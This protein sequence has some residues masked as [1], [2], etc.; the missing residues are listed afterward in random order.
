M[1]F[2]E[3][4]LWTKSTVEANAHSF[5][6]SNTDYDI[7]NY[8]SVYEK[9]EWMDIHADL[10]L[11]FMG[12][13]DHPVYHIT[14]L[15]DGAVKVHGAA[16]YMADKVESRTQVIKNLPCELFKISLHSRLTW[17]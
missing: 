15:T 17:P 12:E 1:F 3:S 16:G 11:E 2:P 6:L 4:N 10:K 7:K 9:Q 8:Q 14:C 5:P 13:T